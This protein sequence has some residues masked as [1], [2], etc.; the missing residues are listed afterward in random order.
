MRGRRDPYWDSAARPGKK[1]RFVL[2]LK[3][4]KPPKG[5]SFSITLD[6]MPFA[7]RQ[8]CPRKL[9]WILSPLDIPL[10]SRRGSA[11]EGDKTGPDCGLR[12]R[13]RIFREQDCK[14]GS[15]F[16]SH[17]SRRAVANALQPP[18]EQPGQLMRSHTGV[19]PDRVYSDGPFPAVGCALTAPFHPYLVG[20]NSALLRPRREAAR[21]APAPFLPP[22]PTKSEDF[23][24]AP[25]GNTR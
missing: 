9:T 25:L 12:N 13:D 2:C 5:R 20:R 18:R 3:D 14:P 8:P 16:D 6:S 19:A 10:I 1:C 4:I 23:A 15:V 21:T 7:G 11:E 17:L 24:G 22:L